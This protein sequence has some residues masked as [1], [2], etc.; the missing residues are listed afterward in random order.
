MREVNIIAED[1]LEDEMLEAQPMRA[2][3]DVM[4]M[5]FLYLCLF[6]FSLASTHIL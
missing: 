6:Q 4:L 1:N 5:I 2:T 3:L